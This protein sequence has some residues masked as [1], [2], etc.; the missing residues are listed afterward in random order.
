MKFNKLWL[1]N[2]NI[3]PCECVCK[4]EKI[5]LEDAK[6]IYKSYEN[7]E[8]A[9]GHETNAEVFSI[10]MDSEIKINRIQAN[11]KPFDLVLSLKLNSRINEGEIL[12]K[13]KMEE[14]GF[15]FYKMEIY[16]LN[17]LEILS[18]G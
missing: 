15:S 13:E 9:I 11:P 8:S 18:Q 17:T 1:F 16:P 7:I 14:I 5:S 3:I 6:K 10:L 4:V 12:T 2:T